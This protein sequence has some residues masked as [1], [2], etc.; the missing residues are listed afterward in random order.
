MQKMCTHSLLL[1]CCINKYHFEKR[2]HFFVRILF[3]GA[4]E[5]RRFFFNEFGRIFYGSLICG[6]CRLGFGALADTSSINDLIEF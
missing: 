1:Y 6:L 5:Q 4:R 2:S 3:S